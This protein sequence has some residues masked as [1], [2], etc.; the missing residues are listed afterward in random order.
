MPTKIKKNEQ[1]WLSKEQE[2]T[3]KIKSE[4]MPFI[5]QAQTSFLISCAFND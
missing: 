5:S 2:M 4:N 3:G 1:G